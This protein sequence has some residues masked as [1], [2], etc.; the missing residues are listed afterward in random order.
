[1]GKRN[2]SKCLMQNNANVG[3]DHS[4]LLGKIG[5]NM[6][7]KNNTRKNNRREVWKTS[8]EELW[9]TPKDLYQRRL[10]GKKCSKP[11]FNVVYYK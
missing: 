9:K 6:E 3:S 11:I 4:F 2:L 1:M 10:T 8:A 5:L 7:R